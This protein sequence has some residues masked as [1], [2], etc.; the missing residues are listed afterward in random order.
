MTKEVNESRNLMILKSE[1]EQ[2]KN[3]LKQ[4]ITTVRNIIDGLEKRIDGEDSYIYASS[5]LQGN[6]SSIDIYLNQYV[7]YTRAIELFER[8]FD[9]D[10]E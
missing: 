7:A 6:S 3:R 8:E 1:Q 10:G 4:Q 9:S 5:G 2:A